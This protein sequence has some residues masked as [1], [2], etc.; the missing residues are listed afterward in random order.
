MTAAPLKAPF[1]WFGG[2]SRVAHLVWERFG[3]VANYVEPF[4][5]SG[6][7]LLGR[8]DWEPGMTETVNDA[9]GFVCNFW[10]A[11]SA[12][13]DQVAEHAYWPAN[14][15]D[16]H[17]RNFVLANRREELKAR[18]EGDPSFFDAEIA[19]WW[20]WGICLWI[21]GEWAT[22]NGPWT[23]VDG[24]LTKTEGGGIS[25]KRPSLQNAGKCVSGKTMAGNH[26][27]RQIVEGPGTF[28]KRPHLDDDGRGVHAKGVERSRQALGTAGAGVQRR[29]LAQTGAF[30]IGVQKRLLHLS[31]NGQ[32]A[33]R[34]DRLDSL[35]GWFADLC[36]RLERVRVCCGDWKRVTG[37]S[38]T[39]K[40]GLTAVFLDPPYE[41]EGRDGRCYVHDH[42]VWEEVWP[43]AVANGQNPLLR[44]A[45]CGYEGPAAH[46]LVEAGWSEVPWKTQGGYG[47]G[48]GK[49]GEANRDRE[50]IWF[51]PHC[52][53]AKD[54]PGQLDLLGGLL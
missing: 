31:S 11:I 24:L 40:H 1:P 20:V 51:S 52:L 42:N 33:F 5:G 48:V 2:K 46:H 29:N 44:I 25:R 38:A 47:A 3:K 18:L 39:V 53:E 41:T 10:R 35:K 23:V 28:R 45:L 32:G 4:F 21:G 14:E 27:E 49:R 13:P 54:V 34:S 9:D 8:P 26:R 17:A 43:W 50:R 30:G 19:G 22:L 36:Y 12:A 37:E 15:N 7:V 6:A 16:L